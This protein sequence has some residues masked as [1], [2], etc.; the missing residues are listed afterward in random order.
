MLRRVMVVGV[1]LALVAGALQAPAAGGK[2][3]QRKARPRSIELPYSEPAIGTAGLGVCFQGS[4]CVFFS[5]L[6]KERYVSVEIEDDLG[7]A[8]YASIIQDTNGDG[9]YLRTDDLTVDICG[10]TTEPVEVEPKKAMSVWVWQ[11][12]GVTAPCVGA[13]SSGTVTATLSTT[14]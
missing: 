3:K 4:S 11:G 12:P 9:A 6:P 10:A 2:K 7:Q 8:V 14:P 1:M 13:A 5:L